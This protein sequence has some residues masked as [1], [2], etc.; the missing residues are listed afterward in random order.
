MK[1][2]MAMVGGLL[3]P[4]QNPGTDQ[5]L[6][7]LNDC[8]IY[9]EHGHRKTVTVTDVGFRLS[10]LPFSI[11]DFVF[12]VIF[13]LRRLGRPIYGFDVGTYKPSKSTKKV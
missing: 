12:Q 6:Q 13:A 3:Q 9:V 10:F 5:L 7:I 8:A 4:R 1:A 11:A 2:H